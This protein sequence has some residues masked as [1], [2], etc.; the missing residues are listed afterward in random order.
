[1]SNKAKPKKHGLH[2]AP[3]MRQKSKLRKR[4]N[5]IQNRVQQEVLQKAIRGA[6]AASGK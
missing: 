6:I 2:L 1:M 3:V 5:K 4:K